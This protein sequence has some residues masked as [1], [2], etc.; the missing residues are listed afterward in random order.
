MDQFNAVAESISGGQLSP[1]VEQQVNQ[2]FGSLGITQNPHVRKTSQAVVQM[3]SNF[4]HGGYIKDWNYCF[5][6]E[7]LFLACSPQERL[8]AYGW[9][10]YGPEYVAKENKKIEYIRYALFAVQMGIVLA[11]FGLVNHFAVSLP[12]SI[13]GLSIVSALIAMANAAIIGK[14]IRG[15]VAKV[16]LMIAKKFDCRDGGILYLNRVKETDL[17]YVQVYLPNIEDRLA[18]LKNLV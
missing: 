14:L 2:M 6:N 12:I 15:I 11:V 5:I 9:A 17:A 16:D 13:I 10:F 1:E 7:Q 3:Y 18:N 8:F 4:K